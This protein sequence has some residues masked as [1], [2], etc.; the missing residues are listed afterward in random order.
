LNKP[1]WPTPLVILIAGSIILTLASG[2]RH[3]GGRFPR[4]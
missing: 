1:T 2:I 3:T 4:R